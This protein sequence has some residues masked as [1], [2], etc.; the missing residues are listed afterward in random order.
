MQ[1]TDELRAEHEG[2]KVMLGVMETVCRRAE[3][4]DPADLHKIVEFLSVFADR[5]HHGKEEDLLFPA[6]EA[7]GVPRDGGPIGVMLEEHT[8]GRELIGAMRDALSEWDADPARARAGFASSALAY[9]ALLRD[10][11][12]KENTVLFVAADRLLSPSLDHELFEGFEEIERDRIGV[13]K[14]EEFHALMDAL[15]AKYQ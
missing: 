8:R 14:H 13:G 6:L 7:A 1:A 15:A 11:I 10:H 9:A 4:A 2:I 12:E 3:P 5:C